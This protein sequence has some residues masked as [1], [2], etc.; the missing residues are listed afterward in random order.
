M[1][2][3]LLVNLGTPDA[4]T[5]R[6][7]RRYLREFLSDP[8][9]IDIPSFFRFLLVN[10]IIAPF[11]SPKSAEAYQKIWTNEGSP[12]LVY[13]K[14]LAE[15][16]SAQLDSSWNVEIGMRYGKPSIREGLQALQKRGATSIRVLPLF[17][18]EADS[19]TGSAVREVLKQTAA[20]GL[21]RPWIL[22]PFF[23]HP[24]FLKSWELV[25]RPV[26]DRVRP[27]HVLISFHGVPE[28]H[29]RKVSPLCLTSA[30]CCEPHQPGNAH[31]YRSHCLQTAQG[32]AQKLGLDRDRWSVS[33]QSRLGRTPW[34]KPFTDLVIPELIRSGKKRMVVISP[35]FVADC[36]ETLEEIGIRARAS[37]MAAGAEAF[38][39][40]PCLNT[41]PAWVETV[42]EMVRSC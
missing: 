7:V 6:S 33:F 18:Q 29:L 22:P 23:A 14:R 41:H 4:P 39:L 3:L 10:G 36:L 42:V 9:V 20:L 30:S 40:V 17:P 28:R 35:S 21:P 16:V 25:A 37:A 32:I 1:T 27:D 8:L 24:G 19:S 26:I 11:R 31:C 38:E 12:L 13:T 5:T 2:G 34:I 15:S